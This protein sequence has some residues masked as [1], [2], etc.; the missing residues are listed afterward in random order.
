MQQMRMSIPLREE[1]RSSCGEVRE[2]GRMVS[3]R[4][5]SATFAAFETDVGRVKEMML[6][7]G[8]G[9]EVSVERRPST[10]E[11]PVWPVAPMIAIIGAI[12]WDW[13]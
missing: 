8:M 12:V 13:E 10:M 3:P 9:G 7:G 1:T 5:E 6:A 4:A 11:R 2:K